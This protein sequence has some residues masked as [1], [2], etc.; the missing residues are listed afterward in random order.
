MEKVGW[1]ERACVGGRLVREW[2][3]GGGNRYGFIVVVGRTV[4]NC[5]MLIEVPE[6]RW[7]GSSRVGGWVS[8]WSVVSSVGNALDEC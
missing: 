1:G 3:R 5:N 4:E 6:F 8:R 2:G 7:K